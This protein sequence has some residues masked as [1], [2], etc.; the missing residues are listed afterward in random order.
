MA[1]KTRRRNGEEEEGGHL[2]RVGGAAGL[3]GWREVGGGVGGEFCGHCWLWDEGERRNKNCRGEREREEVTVATLPLVRSRVDRDGGGQAGGDGEGRCWCC[4]C[5]CWRRKKMKMVALIGCCRYG[6]RER[7]NR[8]RGRSVVERMVAEGTTEKEK[9][10]RETTEKEK[11]MGG[12]LVFCQLWTRFSSS[13]G[14][15]IHLYL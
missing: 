5:R 13:L 9:E 6:E 10:E 15:E 2:T 4:C 7:S 8:W 12:W 11:N 3:G 1:M 14:H